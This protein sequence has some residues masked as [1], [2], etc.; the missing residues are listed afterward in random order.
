MS[1]VSSHL[2]IETYKNIFCTECTRIIEKFYKSVNAICKNY[3]RFC[4]E[5]SCKQEACGTAFVA[6]VVAELGR[7]KQEGKVL[8]WQ[9]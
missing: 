2:K 3:S 6:V 5:Q 9:S 7:D 1:D 8:A 4:L